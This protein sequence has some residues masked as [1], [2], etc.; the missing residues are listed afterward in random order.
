RTLDWKKIIRLSMDTVEMTAAILLIVA[1]ST[2]FA[3]ILTA[4]QVALQFSELLLGITEDRTAVL[5]II[6]LIVLVIGCFMETIAAITILTPVLL[7]VAVHLGVDPVHLGTI[8]VPAL[9][10]GLLTP[11]GGVVRDALWQV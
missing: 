11:P 9:M 4:N 2:I 3:W 6:T 10:I 7:P 5:L 8:T 1:A